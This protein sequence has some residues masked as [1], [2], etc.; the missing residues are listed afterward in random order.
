M[1]ARL[2]RLLRV[3]LMLLAAALVLVALW[4]SLG[5]SLIPLVAEYRAPL[6]TEARRLLG[7]DLHIGSLRGEWQGLMPRLRLEDIE[8]RDGQ[9]ALHLDRLTLRPDLW[10]SLRD[11][12]PRLALLEVEGL[13]LRLRQDETGRWQLKGFSAAGKVSTSSSLAQRLAP[14]AIL[15]RAL[16]LDARLTIE[17]YQQAAFTLADI[18][19]E[20]RTRQQHMTL[21]GHLQLP[22]GQRLQL[23]TTLAL[24]RQQPL[25]SQAQL[26]LQLPASDWSAWLP[27]AVLG[28]GRSLQQLQAGGELWLDWAAGGVQRAMARLQLEQLTFSHAGGSHVLREVRSQAWLQRHAQ[29]WHLQLDGLQGEFGVL[30]LDIGALQLTQQAQGWQVQAAHLDLQAPAALARHLLPLPALGQELLGSLAPRGRIE[31]LALTLQPQAQAQGLPEVEYHMRL[32]QVATGAWRAVPAT[33]NVSGLLSGTL[34]GGTLQL[35]SQDLL[36][37]L[38]TLFPEPW[39]YRQA[40]A[41]LDWQLDAQ[42]FTLSSPLMRLSG[43]EGELA[44]NMLLRLRHDPAAEDYLDLQV[45]LHDGDAAYTRRYLPTRSP[46]LARPLADWLQAAITAGRIEQGLFLY[47]GA[48]NREA[49]PE[50]RALGLYFK[51]RD[52]QLAYQPDWPPLHGLA[53][54]VWVEDSGIRVEA[55]AAQV[56]DSQLQAIRAE[57]R[58]DARGPRLQVEGQISAPL[59]DGLKILQDTPLGRS[60]TFAGWTGTGELQGGLRLDV[61]L[62][63]QGN[64]VQA[65]VDFATRGATL[66]IRQSAL[67]ISQ[68]QGRFRYDSQRGLS[69]EQLRARVL[70][71]A[72]S[73][74]IRAL[75]QGGQPHSRFELAGT[76]AVARLLDWLQQPAAE[77]PASGQLPYR[78]TLD[79]QG[80]EDRLQVDS[81]LRGVQI[82]L[83]APLGKPAD[84]ARPA[85]WRMTLEGAERRYG[86]DYD[87]QASLALAAPPGTLQGLRGELR[88]GGAAAQLPRTPGLQ[89]RGCLPAANLAEWQAL[90]ARYA[91]GR[92]GAGVLRD[93]RLR[94]EQVSLGSLQVNDLQLGVRPEAGGWH[95]ELDSALIAGQV[96]LPAQPRAPWQLTLRHL[97]LPARESSEDKAARE[98][99]G[100]APSDPLGHLDPR[101]L[102][103]FD[104]RIASVMLGTQSLGRWQLR[105]RPQPQGVRFEGLDLQLSGLNLRGQLEWQGTGAAM[106]SRFQGQLG[107]EDAS[108]VLL[109]WGFAPSVSSREFSIEADGHWPGSPAMAA[110]K[111]FSGRLD[112]QAREGQLL[113]VEGAAGLLRVF[114]VLNFN[115]L[116]RR[117]RLDFS[118][119]FGRGL[120]FD[121]L[122]GQLSGT[123]GVFLTSQPLVL[124]GPSTRLDL[125]GQLDMASEQIAA[126]L[127]VTLPLSNNLPLAALMTGALPV[128]G[129]L[130]IVDQLIGDRLSRAAS[131]EYRV[132]GSLQDPQISLFG[133]P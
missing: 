67:E 11:R 60:A 84:S 96:L 77:I 104:A 38:E 54:E 120:S 130:L 123:D 51:V 45:G 78:L 99:A 17:P 8:L 44:G 122:D 87:G 117:L 129:A 66:T 57:V 126:G 58:R 40:R 95:L 1:G 70:G 61:P 132:A 25:D 59:G 30:A 29:G 110:L 16:L 43:E 127:R 18:D 32:N 19:L 31:A 56:L 116:G 24:D 73:G 113:E 114:G 98:A 65:V 68:L 79:L 42:A 97:R 7:Q 55:S 124:D 108:E 3:L 35:D 64:P 111:H 33:G 53:G 119:L 101:Q 46:A 37:H 107:G 26:Y 34:A 36:L 22:D 112:L 27:A 118:D 21:A 115:T 6:E 128:A 28:E 41:Q 47:Q 133:K 94:I 13:Q 72:V 10:A 39:R 125:E 91:G 83:P 76:V 50:A 15:Q 5:R 89:V 52:A 9:Q 69:A 86:L 82:D 20:L 102:P 2:L 62:A 63:A 80:P 4:V 88:L 49:P 92:G 12:A 48:L 74:R 75:G 71:S 100:I 131:V 23:Q 105:A 14:L 103:A 81:D 90:Q 109:A 85:Q 106:R 93:L 121:R